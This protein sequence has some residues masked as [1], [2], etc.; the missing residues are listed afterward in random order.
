MSESVLVVDDD[1]LVLESLELEA[2]DA[3]FRVACAVS[4]PQALELARVNHFD[5]VVCDIRMP[6]MNGLEVIEH[7]K[8]L[9]PY[10]RTMVITGYASPDTPVRALKMRVDDYLLK[11]FDGPTF[12]ASLRGVLDR[13]RLERR[14]APQQ[15]RAHQ[16]ALLGILGQTCDP[17]RAEMAQFAAIRASGLGFSPQRVR[18]VY[19]CALLYEVDLSFLAPFSGLRAVARTLREARESVGDRQPEAR[20]LLE[21]RADFES[22]QREESFTLPEADWIGVENLMRLAAKQRAMEKWIQA[23][24]LYKRILESGDLE[25]D[26]ALD[27]RLEQ[28]IL[29]LDRGKPL[30]SL[31]HEVLAQAAELGL[32]RAEARATLHLARVES[33]ESAAL[34]KARR[35]FLAWDDSVE[36]AACGLLLGAEESALQGEGLRRQALM[37]IPEFVTEE[38]SL[39]PCFVNL[40]GPFRITLD[41]KVMPDSDWVSRKDRLLFAYLCAH[42]GR[43]ITEE[44]LLELL[45]SRGGDRAR[46]SLHNSVSQ[47]RRVLSRLTTLSGKDL[48]ERVGDGYRLGE[49]VK[50]DLGLFREAFENGRRDSLSGAAESALLY[51]RKAESLARSEFM[52]GDYVEWTFPIR[53]EI[54][55]RQIEVLSL[56]ARQYG[57]RRDEE[58]ACRYWRRVLQLDSCREEAYEALFRF[59]KSAG[60]ESEA[61]KLYQAAET[62]FEEELG[63]SVPMAVVHAYQ[64]F[65]SV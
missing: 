40:F 41:G 65:E 19:L 48:V 37:L 43:V 30:A 35:V 5:A 31:G 27:V 58:K 42:A 22:G 54:R 16:D 2:V 21:A 61:F 13:N 25:P 12:L 33:V 4:G 24:D 7:L 60:R 45:W 46:H 39:D 63:L 57:H 32:E 62:S 34:E 20:V 23:D 51:L 9:Q 29:S 1:E 18:L 53:E 11:P 49:S 14:G 44:T 28:F 8:R 6:G 3:G 55:D 17:G 59:L 50:V 26:M 47:T 38:R 52:E 36:A 64:R 10:I 56:L 15:G